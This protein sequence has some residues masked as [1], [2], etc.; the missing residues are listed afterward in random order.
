MK[1]WL[2]RAVFLLPLVLLGCASMT[3][4]ECKVANWG[5]VGLRDGL[6]GESLSRLNDLVKDCAEA[7][8][9]V[10]TP[11]YLAGRDRG[12]ITYCQLDNA[13]RLGLAGRA[14]LGSCP[15][16]V[17]G[18]FRRRFDL[19]REVYDARQQVQ[20]LESRRYSLEKKL[21][22]AESDEAR[23]EA[24]SELARL[25]RD[26]RRARDRVRDAEWTFDRMR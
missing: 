10:N 26:Y 25:D 24:R 2:M 21:K 9:S 23:K 12:L 8:V 4:K 16:P 22:D 6:G 17:N 5:E 11:I 19:G 18:E 13:A 15:A 7:G 20:R 3:A 14:Y 1:R